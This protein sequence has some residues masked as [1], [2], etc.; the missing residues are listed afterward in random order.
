MSCAKCQA[1]SEYFS[2]AGDPLCRVCYFAEQT[3]AQDRRAIESLAED[4]GM[5]VEDF[6]AAG[7]NIQ[8][9]EPVSPLAHI[10]WGVLMILGAVA[11]GAF[12][13]FVL[14][15]IHPLIIGATA[16]GGLGSIG[17]GLIAKRLM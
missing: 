3:K 13:W 7:G 12:E 14:D 4:A 10:G 1:P 17:R 2:S 6:Q 15:D 8:L 11:F 5:S 16:L 9:R